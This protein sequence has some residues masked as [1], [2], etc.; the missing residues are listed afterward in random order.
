MPVPFQ[1]TAEDYK[2][3]SAANGVWEKLESRVDKLPNLITRVGSI[4]LAIC[5]IIIG[6]S[7]PG[8]N[9]T[10]FT[11]RVA[12]LTLILANLA[13]P[14]FLLIL[15]ARA[16]TKSLRKEPRR[17]GLV[18]HAV[19]KSPRH[20]SARRTV[21]GI[22]SWIL[23][24]V[25]LGGLFWLD[26]TGKTAPGATS[27]PSVQPIGNSVELPS[28]EL[29][30][31][32]FL[33]LIIALMLL[34][35]VQNKLQLKKYTRGQPQLFEPT[36]LDFDH[37]GISLNSQYTHIS[38]KWPAIVKFAE[39]ENLFLVYIS[40]IYFH[41]V[42]KRALIV[43]G[44]LEAFIV[45]LTSHVSEGVLLPRPPTGFPVLPVPVIPLTPPPLPPSA[46]PPISREP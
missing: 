35:M 29:L 12:P 30:A 20:L 33:P 38:L 10:S 23:F 7:R 26:A 36:Q 25:I 11:W 17:I 4:A 13:L 31:L 19:P 27:S 21:I 32:T 22:G 37:A 41:L 44:Q 45:A 16:L 2:E 34:G 28:F 1:C 15:M 5:L 18:Q 39:S 46:L 42:P 40:Q 6:L 8:Q 9:G 24:F 3:A 14:G 43:G